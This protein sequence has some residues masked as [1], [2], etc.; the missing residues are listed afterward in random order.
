MVDTPHAPQDNHIYGNIQLVW[1]AGE[2]D[3]LASSRTA[4][5]DQH[6]EKSCT[7]CSLTEAEARKCRMDR[8]REQNRESQRKFRARK[9][10]KIREAASQVAALEAYV[11]F[12]EK[13]N[14]DLEAL[15][16]NLQQQIACFDSDKHLCTTDMSESASEMVHVIPRDCWRSRTSATNNPT[17]AELPKSF[18]AQDM[19]LCH[20]DH[21]LL[22][23]YDAAA[24]NY[25]MLDL[26]PRT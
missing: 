26:I 17:A 3:D 8:R 7:R 24:D 16:A 15:N 10:A 9:E 2:G 13:H 19:P 20:S 4:L 14:N 1:T 22:L 6:H 18:H 25:Q 12:L 21:E 11:E 23:P 5:P